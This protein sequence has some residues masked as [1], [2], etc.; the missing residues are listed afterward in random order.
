MFYRY[1]HFIEQRVGV[2]SEDHDPEA[3]HYIL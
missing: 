1:W 3:Q 2:I